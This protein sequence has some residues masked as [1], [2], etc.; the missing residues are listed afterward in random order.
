LALG[1]AAK[2]STGPLAFA[3]SLRRPRGLQASI[4]FSAKLMTYEP[5]ILISGYRM[6]YKD[7][8]EWKRKR[9]QEAFASPK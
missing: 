8:E 5:R 9:G 1:E 2:R 7:Y 6:T 4:A 3:G